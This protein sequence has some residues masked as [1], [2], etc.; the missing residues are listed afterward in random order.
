M[1]PTLQETEPQIDGTAVPE[2]TLEDRIPPALQLSRRTAGTVFGLGLIYFWFCLKPLWHT[3]LWGHLAYG[4]YLWQHG[5]LPATEPLMPLARGVPFVDSAWL[6]QLVGYW[7]VESFGIA[8]LQGLT[9]L[10]ILAMVGLFYHRLFQ[11]TRS[12]LCAWLGT[13]SLLWLNWAN[14]SVTRPQ[15]AGL[16]MF[17]VVLHRLTSRQPR[18]SDIASVPLVMLLWANLHG[19]FVMGLSLMGLFLFGR[20]IDLARRTGTWRSW[21][22]DNHVRRGWVWCQLSFVASLVN[23]WG[24]GLYVHIF[25]VGRNPNLQAL[26]EWHPLNIRALHGMVFVAATLALVVLYRLTPRRIAAWEPLTLISLSVATLWSARFM[27]WWGPLAALLMTVHFHAV[28][29]RWMSWR[30]EP[31]ESPKNGKWSV[32]SMG[33]I[34]IFFAYSPL[35]MRLVHHKEPDPARALS[36]NTPL[37]IVAWLNEHPPQGLVF[38]PYEWGDYLLWAGPAELQIFLNSHAHLVP[39][40]VWTH[41]LAVMDQTVEGAEVLRRYGV[42]TVILDAEYRSS[43]IRKMKDDPEWKLAYEDNRGAVFQR[44]RSI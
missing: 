26:T 1:N 44:K 20:M 11:W 37:G 3:D 23:P 16:L 34:W 17:V 19:S 2:G 31:A 28:C 30:A 27:V 41:Y 18:S 13:A 21:L 36:N 24:L 5:T 38:N 40:E 10:V 43:L 4:R 39:A 12:G 32:V 33:L 15:L 25:D 42:N 22:H 14:L 7:T 6:S 29:R 9:A 35:G 8:G